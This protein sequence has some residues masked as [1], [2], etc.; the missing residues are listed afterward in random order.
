MIRKTMK[1]YTELDE[2]LLEA[3]KDDLKMALQIVDMMIEQDIT[4]YNAEIVLNLCHD[5]IEISSKIVP[6]K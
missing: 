1:T 6:M 4:S 5:L 3:N 2:R